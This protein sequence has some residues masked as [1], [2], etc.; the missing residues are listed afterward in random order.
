MD[1]LNTPLIS[2]KRLKN[3]YNLSFISR[4]FPN[5]IINSEKQKEGYEVK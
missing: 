1:F 2:I 5:K 4:E 3:N